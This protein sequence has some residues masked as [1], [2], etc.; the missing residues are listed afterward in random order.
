[1]TKA[2]VT[3]IAILVIGALEGAAIATGMDGAML[4]MAFTAIGGLAG[5][6]VGRKTT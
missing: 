4:A 6:T 3:A 5:F 1:M 2:K